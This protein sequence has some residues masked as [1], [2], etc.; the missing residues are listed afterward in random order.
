[1]AEHLR[2]GMY[3]GRLPEPGRKPGGVE[4][5]VHRLANALVARGHDVTVFAYADTALTHAYELSE[6]RPKAAI[7]S[8]P[9]K[10]Y[11]AS[12]Q[13]NWWDVQRFDV[14]H[15]HGDDW[16][17][18][19]RRRPTVRTFHGSALLECL[20]AKSW[21]HRADQA[22]VFLLELHAARLASARYGVGPDSRTIYGC[23]GVLRTGIELPTAPRHP[24]PYPL[25]SFIGTWRGRKRGALLHEVFQREV[26]PKVPEARLCMVADHCEPGPNV[27]WL[28]Q[29]SDAQITELLLSSWAFCLPSSYEGFGIPYLE[30]MACGAPVV[31]TPNPG[32]EDLVRPGG[33]GIVVEAQDL[34]ES[35]VMVLRSDEL[36]ARLASAGKARAAD[37]TWDR[38]GAQHE[39]A[40]ATAIARFH[41]R[42][43]D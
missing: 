39:A 3:A 35:L 7:R 9:L 19:R 29:P 14:L 43:G 20:N 24:A 31:A 42:D 17:Y 6:L 26:L 33:A 8:R 2:V 32:A 28:K 13:F 12:W 5:Y 23:D 22:A 37:F 1:V 36:R 18:L 4:V 10:K 25:I 41:Q 27:T 16:F 40:Y 34:G 30:A 15:F 11:V 38:V 21:R